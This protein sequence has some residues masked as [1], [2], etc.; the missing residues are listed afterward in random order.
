MKKVIVILMIGFLNPI[1]FGQTG[2][3]KDLSNDI[4]MNY[5]FARINPENI[6]IKKLYNSG[7]YV[8]IYQISDSKATP[9]NFSEGTEEFLISYIISITEDGDYYTGSKLYKLEGLIYPENLEIKELVYPK[10]LVSIEHGFYN[11][12]KLESFIFDG[13]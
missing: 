4:E 13:N 6:V 2:K 3:I 8:T 11:K 1:C 9:E 7:L 10:F 5:I 12:R